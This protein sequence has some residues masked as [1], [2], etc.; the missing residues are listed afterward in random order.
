MKLSEKT[1]QLKKIRDEVINLKKSPLYETRIENGYHAVIGEGNHD[2]DIMFVGEA[3]GRNEA[4]QGRPFCGRAGKLL[5][6]LLEG[7]GIPRSEVYITNIVKDRPPENRDPLPEEIEL[8]TPFLDRQI[9]I[10]Q[11]KVLVPLGRHAMNYLLKKYN[12]E[13]DPISQAHGK[14][15]EVSGLFGEMKIIPMYHP[16]AAI[17]TSSLLETLKEDFKILKQFYGV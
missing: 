12:I 1:Q 4:E 15:Y 11:P 9:E 10:I 7:I 3:P 8:Y 14:I 6:E 17:Y 13:P 5:D 2:T 16:A